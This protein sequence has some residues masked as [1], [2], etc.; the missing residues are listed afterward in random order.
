MSKE[1][2]KAPVEQAGG[3]ELEKFLAWACKE[4]GIEDK[5]DLNE[6]HHSIRENKKGGWPAPPWRNPPQRRLN[7]LRPQPCVPPLM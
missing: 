5:Y 2:N 3:D 7:P 6:N 4:Y 1:L